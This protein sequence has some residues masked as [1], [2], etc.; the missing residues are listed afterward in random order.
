MF[1]RNLQLLLQAA[2]LIAQ[3]LLLPHR[4]GPQLFHTLLGGASSR[5]FPSRPR[6]LRLAHLVLHRPQILPDRFD[7]L[8]QF[9]LAASEVLHAGLHYLA[10]AVGG[11]QLLHR[12]RSLHRSQPLLDG[13][14]LPADPLQR[15][16]Q[17]AGTRAVLVLK[18]LQLPLVPLRQ[19]LELFQLGGEIRYLLRRLRRRGGRLIRLFLPR[20]CL[21]TGLQR[22]GII[23]PHALATKL[24]QLLIQIVQLP[25]N[26]ADLA[27][28]PASARLLAQRQLLKLRFQ[29][30]GSPGQL[31]PLLG[32]LLYLLVNAPQ[33]LTWFGCLGR[34]GRPGPD[35]RQTIQL[36]LD[37][38]DTRLQGLNVGEQDLC[39]V[40]LGSVVLLQ[41][42]FG[43]AC[44]LLRRLRLLLGGLC[45]RHGRRI[46]DRVDCQNVQR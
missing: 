2:N 34:A 30:L 13:L 11:L 33:F 25:L 18:L 42:G 8:V 21:L 15:R 29:L 46:H 38:L 20:A 27:L 44:P 32:H 1:G 43:F 26:P 24:R 19:F 9:L 41:R 45:R 35:G 16:L 28:Q 14:Y 23:G 12:L 40:I 10:L 4:F 3:L 17:L 22:R 31:G 5:F 7:A 36:R 6:L 39:L 37:I